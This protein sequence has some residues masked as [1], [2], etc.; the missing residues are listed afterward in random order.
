MLPQ[1]F[2]RLRFLQSFISFIQSLFSFGRLRVMHCTS[3]DCVSP[4]TDIYLEELPEKIDGLLSLKD[5]GNLKSGW[6]ITE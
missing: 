1:H 4:D 2:F 5:A 6:H 3:R